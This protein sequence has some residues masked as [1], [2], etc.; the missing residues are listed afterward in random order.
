MMARESITLRM[1]PSPAFV[2]SII[3]FG[4]MMFFIGYIILNSARIHASVFASSSSGGAVPATQFESIISNTFITVSAS[5]TEISNPDEALIYVF[6]NSTGSSFSSA[7]ENLSSGAEL[8]NS[9]LMPL[10]GGNTSLIRTLYYRVYTPPECMNIT[11]YY[12][13]KPYY[14]IQPLSPKI[15][16]ASEYI[17][18]TIP[19]IVNVNQALMKI[20]TIPGIGI[21]DVS[22]TLSN[23]KQT[24]MMQ[25]ALALAMYNATSQA[26]AVAGSGVQLKTQNISISGGYV[27]YPYM[28]NG[29]GVFASAASYS[30][31]QTFFPGTATITKNVY[32]IFRTI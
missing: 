8:L 1:H 23:Q 11:P 5:G 9:T 21:S 13:P 25:E 24:M 17:L 4:L 26:Q 6:L 15:Y 19:D 27:I 12:Y 10:L 31:N 3:L 29:G 16:I 30:G 22:S 7:V 20:S 2:F 14:C 28:T 32:V 18:V